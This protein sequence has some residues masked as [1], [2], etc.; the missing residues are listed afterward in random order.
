MRL[1]VNNLNCNP[2]STPS[3]IAKV[4]FM[5]KAVT[6]STP[7]ANPNP[8]FPEHVF[9]GDL[10]PVKCNL[11]VLEIPSMVFTFYI[12]LFYVIISVNICIYIFYSTYSHTHFSP[13]LYL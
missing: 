2:L 7:I 5:R 3:P 6:A 10:S 12:I 4:A 13:F 9:G 1:V 11:S 8:I